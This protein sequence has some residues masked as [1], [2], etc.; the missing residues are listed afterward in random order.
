MDTAFPV[1]TVV[2][3][4]GMWFCKSHPWRFL[5]RPP[6]HL[7]L[8]GTINVVAGTWIQSTNTLSITDP[9]SALASYT[10]LEGDEF[11]VTGGTNAA[12]GFYKVKAR[13]TD[14]N[15]SF[16]TS[17]G[18]TA[19]GFTDIA[20]TMPLPSVALPADFGELIGDPSSATL[21]GY[22]QAIGYNDLV[23]L[24]AYSPAGVSPFY[25][26]AVTFGSA[27]GDRGGAPVA[28]LELD[29]AP[30][31]G[32]ANSI[33]IAYRAK[34]D[35]PSDDMD[36][37]RIPDYCELAF[38]RAVR[39]CARGWEEEDSGTLG[40]R[41]AELKGSPEYIDAVLAD[42]GVTSSVGPMRGGGAQPYHTRGEDWHHRRDV[43]VNWP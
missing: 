18:A 11:Q 14:T 36:R 3:Q 15:L 31:T 12:A 37:I 7:S 8:R 30:T 16:T 28:R 40:P 9:A 5:I 27:T 24:R 29:R 26:Y 33:V 6:V 4:A 17:I 19:N 21:P 13:L 20:G 25:Y 38:I 41:L 23:S 10:F 42:G 32:S 2:Q 35:P 43:V 39:A 1:K 34:F 22:F